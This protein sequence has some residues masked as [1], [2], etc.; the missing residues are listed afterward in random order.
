MKLTVIGSANASN[1]AG[2]GHSCYW[3]ADATREGALMV[4]FGATALANL[5]RFGF[6]PYDLRAI[7]LTHLHGDHIGGLAFL[8]VEAICMNLRKRP[9]TIIGPTGAEARVDELMRV[10]YRSLS[11]KTPPFELTWIE[12]APGEETELLGCTVRGFPA[13]HQDPPEAPL[14]LQITA[15]DGARL[16]FSGDT[17][18]CDGLRAA[19]QG[20][21]LLVAECS[22]LA[23]PIGRHITWAE[24][25]PL[26]PGF[27]AEAY[28]LTHL[29]AEVRA[30]AAELVATAPVGVTLRFADDGMELDV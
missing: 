20:V 5:R 27:G 29:S 23:P 6:D 18:M 11:Q 7:A 8:L 14:C 1:D 24:W 15:A 30:A 22:G 17:K 9:L 25:K 26:L 19:A 28:L 3:L 13:L 16:A 2:R 21:Q 4:D 10:A 12:L